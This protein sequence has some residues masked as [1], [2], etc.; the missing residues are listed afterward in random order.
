MTPDFQKILE[1]KVSA[2]CTTLNAL[3]KQPVLTC[4]LQIQLG[5]ACV[6]M[7]LL[8]M[9]KLLS[10]FNNARKFFAKIKNCNYAF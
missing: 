9:G 10:V 1:R 4:Q 8:E 2:I 7:V 5:I 3:M 6:P